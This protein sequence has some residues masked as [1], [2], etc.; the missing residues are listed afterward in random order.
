MGFKYCDKDLMWF[1]QNS[2]IQEVETGT[3]KKNEIVITAKRAAA[4]KKKK[5]LHG[6]EI[7]EALVNC[8]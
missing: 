6:S 2:Y 5:K 7:T 3:Y 8:P 4:K 1:K